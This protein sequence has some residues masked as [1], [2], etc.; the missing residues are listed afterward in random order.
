MAGKDEFIVMKR[1]LLAI[2]L[3]VI[4][5]MAPMT[6]S[7]A[8]QEPQVLGVSIPEQTYHLTTETKQAALAAGLTA[9]MVPGAFPTTFE[10]LASQTRSALWDGPVLTK[11]GGVNY[12]PNGK[13]TYYNLDMSGVLKLMWNQGFVGDYWVRYDGVKMFGPFIMVA[14]NLTLHP[15]GSLVETSL[16]TGIVCDTG[17]FAYHNPTQVDIAVAW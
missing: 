8:E 11:L 1:K 2:A 13:E 15:R 5:L 12:G 7:A 6:V 4:F 17:G 9:P 3:C 16:G 14:A 10:G